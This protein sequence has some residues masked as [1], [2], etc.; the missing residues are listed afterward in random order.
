MGGS[1][2]EEKTENGSETVETGGTCGA[3][4]HVKHYQKGLRSGGVTV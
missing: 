1:M 2:M 3:I 4:I